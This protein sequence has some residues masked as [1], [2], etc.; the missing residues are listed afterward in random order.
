MAFRAVRIGVGARERLRASLA[1]ALALRHR[2]Q[3]PASAR[4]PAEPYALRWS[5]GAKRQS[6][7]LSVGSDGGADG[8]ALASARRGEFRLVHLDQRTGPSQAPACIDSGPVLDDLGPRLL[9]RLDAA[10]NREPGW[11][12][13]VVDPREVEQQVACARALC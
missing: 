6:E 12:S 4:Q 13:A 9:V 3:L 8:P 2:W 7:R 10:R 1:R 11:R 5:V